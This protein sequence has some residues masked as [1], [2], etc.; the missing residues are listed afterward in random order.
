MA[1]SSPYKNTSLSY[2]SIYLMMSKRCYSTEEVLQCLD[3][4]SD[5]HFSNHD[6]ESD[7]NDSEIDVVSFNPM[8][9]PSNVI[10]QVSPSSRP[11]SDG[12]QWNFHSLDNVP[13]D[14]FQQSSPDVSTSISSSTLPSSPIL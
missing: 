2:T 10:Q 12:V 8:D 6:S 7:K 11:P 5:S 9:N 4:D 3:E 14:A 13:S 1:S